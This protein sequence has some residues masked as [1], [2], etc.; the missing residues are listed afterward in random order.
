MYNSENYIEDTVN[1]VL[2]QT[3]KNWELLIIDDG[4]S[5]KS[6]EIAEKYRDKDSRI[7]LLQNEKNCGVVKTRNNGIKNAN[8][9]YI[10]F[11]DSDD[12][13]D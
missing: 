12:L 13:W 2:K 1:S 9:R 6:M 4:S 3:Y 8:G 10:A 7:K 5:D 11:L